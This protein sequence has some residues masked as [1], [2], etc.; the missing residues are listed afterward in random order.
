MAVS[1]IEAFSSIED[2]RSV[3]FVPLTSEAALSPAPAAVCEGMPIVDQI[4]TELSQHLA[5]LARRI[6]R[7]GA[8]SGGTVVLVT[9]CQRGVG[10]TTVAVALSAVAAGERSVLLVDADLSQPGVVQTMGLSVS[11]GWDEVVEQNGTPNDALVQA[12]PRMAVLPLR[13]T[14][15]GRTETLSSPLALEWLARFRQEY[16]LIVVDGGSVW[17]TGSQWAPM[18]DA[19]IV[20]GDSDRAG[21]D[22]WASAW[23]RLEEGGTHVMGIVETFT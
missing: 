8:V 23:D 6:Q 20:I 15:R 11:R 19:A 5:E 3:T 18:V 17:E 16:S 2:F 14:V 1:R 9:G 13:S 7:V 12:N 4:T 21:T 10:C 22:E